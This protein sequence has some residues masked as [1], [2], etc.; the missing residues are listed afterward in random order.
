M[1]FDQYPQLKL[2]RVLWTFSTSWT[3]RRQLPAAIDAG[4]YGGLLVYLVACLKE[5]RDHKATISFN[6]KIHGLNKFRRYLGIFGVPQFRQTPRYRNKVY[7]YME[8]SV[9]S[10]SSPNRLD[11]SMA[12]LYR[13]PSHKKIRIIWRYLHFRKP[14]NEA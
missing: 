10:F 7:L 8:I 12:G 14:T 13:G 2:R 1:A 9:L 5:I 4:G 3:V 11:A 6:T